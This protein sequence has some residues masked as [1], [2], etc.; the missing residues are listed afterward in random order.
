MAHLSRISF[1]RDEERY[2]L[3]LDLDD[4]DIVDNRLTFQLAARVQSVGGRDHEVQVTLV[5]DFERW[6]ATVTLPDGSEHQVNISGVDV[7]I[8][9]TGEEVVVDHEDVLGDRVSEGIG[10]A[11]VQVLDDIPL[12]DPL[13]CLIKAG[14]SSTIGQAIACREIAGPGFGGMLRCLRD[15]VGAIFGRT[16]WRTARCMLFA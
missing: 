14:V 7:R 11:L 15:H 10:G 16:L 12:G 4:G 13:A 1:E 3:L 2:E 8:S 6:V 9:P 5:I